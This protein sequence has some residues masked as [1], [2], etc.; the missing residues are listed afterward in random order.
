MMTNPTTIV[1]AAQ[2][3]LTSMSQPRSANSAGKS[4]AS[5]RTKIQKLSSWLAESNVDIEGIVDCTQELISFYD[6]QEQQY[7]EKLVREQIHRFLKARGL[8]K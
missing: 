4:N 7:N 2:A 6:V 1:N 8:D 3:A 5:P